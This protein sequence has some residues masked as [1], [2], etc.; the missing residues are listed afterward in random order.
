MSLDLTDVALLTQQN[1]ELLKQLI[2]EFVTLRD[3]ISGGVNVNNFPELPAPVINLPEQVVPTAQEFDPSALTAALGPVLNSNASQVSERFTELKQ[4]LES[5]STEIQKSTRNQPMRMGG[6][7]NTVRLK[8]KTDGAYINPATEETLQQVRD[9]LG[10]GLAQETTLS[11][12]E[13]KAAT[14]ATLTSIAGYVDQLEGLLTTIR[15]EQYRRTDPL[16]AGTNVLGKVGLDPSVSN[17]VS[18]SGTQKVGQ[19][20]FFI[21]GK[22]ISL[23]GVASSDRAVFKLANPSTSGHVIYVMAV[24]IYSTVSQQVKY[25]EDGTI[26]TEGTITPR[27]LNRSSA[28]TS[29]AELTYAKT[30]IT[31]GTEW[32]NESRVFNTSP[33]QLNFSSSPIVLPPGKS[34]LI[35]GTVGDAQ[36]F[37]VN[38][39]WIEEPI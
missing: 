35:R 7:K 32:P 16:A 39:Y 10:T 9:G 31:G 36:T 8:D 1:R 27:N 19:G 23:G 38:G 25:N 13:T 18:S 37:T 28:T 17:Y 34:I 3:V 22:A 30:A 29:I 4:V 12:L 11:A 6:G 33:L 15:D 26:T 14:E 24:T 2:G 20:R 5:L 21:G